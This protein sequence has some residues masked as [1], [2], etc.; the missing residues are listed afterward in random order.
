MPPFKPI[1]RDN[2][3]RA[4][5]R[6]GFDGPFSGG[7]HQFMVRKDLTITVPN[8]HKGDIGRDLLTR[9][10]KQAGISREEFEAA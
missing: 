4:L 10:L 9:I 2:L 7:R 1:S 5:R 6:L 8:P 3:I